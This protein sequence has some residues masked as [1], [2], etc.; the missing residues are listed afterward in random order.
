MGALRRYAPLSGAL[1]AV[2]WVASLVV[3]EAGGNPADPDSA[4]E[5]ADHFRDD[6]GAILVAGTLHVLGGF[7]F[8]WFLAILGTALAALDETTA[9]LRRGVLVGGT[10][11]GALMLALTGPQTT[12]ATT[13]VELIGPESSVAFWRLSHAFFV[14]A[15]YAFAV[16][17]A[18]LA[19]LAFAGFLPR[20][21]AWTGIVIAVLLLIVPLG[22]IALLFLLPLW[23]IAVSVVLFSRERR[24]DS[25]AS[26]SAS[27]DVGSPT[28]AER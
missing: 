3:L 10:A 14:G 11:A 25:S 26:G 23:L 24:D 19:L 13:D 8:L 4:E 1:A 15:E 16:F 22:W 2:L 27:A 21:L 28:P 17:V 20:W 6:R 12:G 9:W 5:I 18:A 7:F